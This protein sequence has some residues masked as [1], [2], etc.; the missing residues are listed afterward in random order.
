MSNTN[1][2][3]FKKTSNPQYSEFIALSRYSRW[4]PD[5]KRRE[6]WDETV[7]RL[8]SFW[9][10]RIKENKYD[11]SSKDLDEIHSAI[12]NLEV[13]PSMR[14]LMAAGAALERD[15]VAAYN[16]SAAHIT[17]TGGEI[18]LWSDEL[19]KAGIDEPI[20]ITLKHPI[21][22]DEI[23]YVLMC[24]VGFGFSVERQFIANLPTVGKKVSRKIYKR[25]EDNYPGVDRD[26]ISTY[27]SK[28][29]TIY[30]HDSKYGWSSALRI[31]IVELYNNNND[32]TWDLS[33]LRPAG[34]PLKTF[35]GRAS[36]PAPLNELFEFIRNMFRT[37]DGRKLTSVECHDLVCK[38]AEVVVVGGVRRSALL[39]LSNLSDERMR[40]AKS[41]AW[42]ED[43]GQRRLANNSAVYTEKP[44]IEI[45][46]EEWLALVTSKSGERG[47]F[48][49]Y[50][51]LMSIPERRKILNYYEYITNPCGEILLRS[52]G[53]CNLTE[54]VI[55]WH[56]T[57]KS[58][59]RK[60]RIAT[61]LGTLQATLTNFKY[62]S[63]EWQKNAEEERL[64]GVSFTGIMDNYIM[65]G[66]S[67]GLLDEN[68]NI[69]DPNGKDLTLEHKLEYFQDLAINTNKIWAAKLGINEASAITTVKP[70][71]TVSQLVDSSS[72]IHTRYAPYYIRTVRGDKK[73]PIVRYMVDAGFYHEDDITKPD[74]TIIF[75]FP[76]KA[77]ANAIFQKDKTAIEQLELWKIYKTH[78]TEHNPS[79][80]ITVCDDEWLEVGAWVYK[81]LD[82]IVGVSFLP[83][84]NHTYKQAPYQEI[85]E[86]E[87]NAWLKKMP[88]NVDWSKLS[89]YELEDTTQ[90]TKELSCSGGACEIVD[91]T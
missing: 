40:L 56:D 14:S 31:L 33:K 74:S 83:H 69:F 41:G 34:A 3:A 73:D 39:G 71:G 24:S 63:H 91:L 61:I 89:E 27:S 52:R 86:D 32:V 90:G 66:S 55:R 53:L 79:V 49:R 13:L 38:I 51:A 1:I 60:V 82:D 77:P 67:S 65:S 17:G 15:E 48:S 23:M 12:Y 7:N 59:K 19:A 75:S 58:I 37:I 36:G 85:S 54:V 44:S 6:S 47:V 28:Y 57:F 64:L 9:K 35:G 16:C 80:T 2:E 68:W 18:S 42:W 20:K 72:G 4:L 70:S 62:L 50:G 78:W 30:V 21:V 10:K 11:I 29:N 87:Y 81:Y 8:M 76:I 26:E 88:K 45:F 46:M 25:T 22:F 43:N 5:K 84:S